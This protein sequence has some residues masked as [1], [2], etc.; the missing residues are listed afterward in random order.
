[1]TKLKLSVTLDKC[2]SYFLIMLNVYAECRRAKCCYAV[3][4]HAECRYA[5]CQPTESR[6][7]VENSCA[8]ISVT[9]LGETPVFGYF[10][11][12]HFLHFQPNKQFQN[13]VCCSC[14]N[15]QKELSPHVL[16]FPCELWYFCYSFGHISKYWANS[17]S[18][19]WSLWPP[20]SI[21][22]RSKSETL[23]W[24]DIHKPTFYDRF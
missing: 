21:W 12:D 19:F 18:I 15:V 11:H 16:G 14:F 13:M 10:L 4:C 20:S 6:S 8:P 5:E 2:A 9:R 1:M 24:A 7:A 23:F 17:C 22:T 3:C